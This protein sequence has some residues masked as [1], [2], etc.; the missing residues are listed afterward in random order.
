[1]E[2]FNKILDHA[3]T[4]ICNVN[5]YDWDLRIPTIIWV[6]WNTC[7]KLIEHTPF[8]LEYNQEAI[9]PMEFNVSSLRIVAMT[10]LTEFGAVEKILSELVELE[11]D[12][13]IARFHLQV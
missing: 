12:R 6:Y 1:V 2:V 5:Q 11:E 13:F 7:K 3:L 8:R 9:T 4:K 10:E